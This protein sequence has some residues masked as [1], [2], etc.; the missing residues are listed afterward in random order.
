MPGSQ[1]IVILLISVISSLC[2]SAAAQAAELPTKWAGTYSP[3]NESDTDYYHVILDQ[4][5]IRQNT[6]MAVGH[7]RYFDE[8]YVAEIKM[9]WIINK[10][11]L[12]VQMWDAAPAASNGNYD[13]DGVYKG[14]ISSDLQSILA[15]WHNRDNNNSGTLKLEAVERFPDYSKK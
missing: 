9:E 5:I 10:T 11:T 14:S 8:G 12:F 13:S 15:I 2:P 7:G 6:I 1:V 4:I 3:H